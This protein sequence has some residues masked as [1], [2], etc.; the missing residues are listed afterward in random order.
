MIQTGDNPMEYRY[1]VALS[2]AG[3]DRSFAENVAKGLREAGVKVF[4]DDFY[5]EELWGEDL[6]A[7][8]REVYHRSSQFCIMVISK[9]YVDKMWP[10]HE[11]Q[12]AVERM[13]RE[14]GKA[15]V[16]PVR[17]DGFNGEVPG[18]SGAISYLAV[19]SSDHQKIVDAFLRKIG[20]KGTSSRPQSR[21]EPAEAY[22]PKIKKSFTDKE[23]NLFL[24]SSFNEIVTLIDDFAGE[25]QKKYSHFEYEK[26]MVTSRKA[27]FTLY[28]NGRQVTR[29]KIW[30]GGLLGGNSIC[31]AHG[32]S[33]DIDSDSSMNE[34]VSLEMHEGE[35]KL[36]PMGIATF[37]S[38]RDKLMSPREV[39]DYLWQIA[40]R[41]FQ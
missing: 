6:A 28:E 5:A 32:K 8:L 39:A 21:K 3:E 11:R 7:K 18:L 25:T 14:R 36:K 35:L 19:K 16:L 24:T 10:S 22:I 34:S 2:F 37:G 33:I 15:Y 13:I 1:E 4:Y 23:K 31:F 20:R 12:Q 41:N 38:E 30:I 17:L 29:F 27:V 26:E 9:H 40:C